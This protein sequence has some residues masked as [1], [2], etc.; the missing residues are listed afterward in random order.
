MSKI[1]ECIT[2]DAAEIMVHSLIT[3]KLDYCNSILNCLPDNN[4]KSL[5]SVQKAAA[6]LVSKK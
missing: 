1:R 2:V 6:R 3:T 5:I 4:L